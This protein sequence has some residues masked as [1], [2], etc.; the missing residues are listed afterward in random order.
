MPRLRAAYCRASLTA[1][2]AAGAFVMRLA[3]VTMPFS[4][5]SMTPRLIPSECPKSS[6]F[7]ITYRVRSFIGA[8]SQSGVGQ[9]LRRTV[10]SAP[11]KPPPTRAEA[12]QRASSPPKAAPSL[13][14]KILR[15]S[16]AGSGLEFPPASSQ[17]TE[18]DSLEPRSHSPSCTHGSQ[19]HG[20]FSEALRDAFP[21]RPSIQ[22]QPRP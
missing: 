19:R 13:G 16:E 12:N 14:V 2:S 11:L 15:R 4:W 8:P 9:Q 6:A 3:L 1:A 17:R 20:I 7:T 5:A 10:P 22:D 21:V 18:V